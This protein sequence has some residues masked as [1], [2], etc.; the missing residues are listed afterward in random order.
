MTDAAERRAWAYLSRVAEPPCPALAALVFE[1]G[2]IEAAGL[3]R[4]G[5]APDHVAPHVA[6]RYAEDRSGPDLELLTVRGGRLVTPDDDEWPVLALTAFAGAEA[7]KRSR[8]AA[9]LVL[10]A[11]GPALLDDVAER[12]VAMVGTRAATAYGEYVAA[13]LAAGLVERDVA[14]V[15]GGAY[16]L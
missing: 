16:V 3:I 7:R 1:K 15:S 6:A 8:G 5:Q 10:W 12:S 14:V 13:D 11:M 9:P 2:P 4:R